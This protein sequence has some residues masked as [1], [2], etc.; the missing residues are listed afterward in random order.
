MKK[1]F[2]IIF[3]IYYLIFAIAAYAA[4]PTPTEKATPTPT[5]SEKTD[6][7][8]TL[9]ERI[10]SRVAELKL[11]ERRGIIGKV[12][13]V[14]NSQITLS[15]PNGNI[16]FVDVDELTKFASPSAKESFGISDIKKDDTLGI[17]G[18]YNKQSRRLLAR[19]IDV[20]VQQQFIHGA[21]TSLNEK[22]FIITVAT[23]DKKVLLVDVEKITKTLSYENKT[24]LT[25][26]GFSKIEEGQHII[27]IGFFDVKDK[28]R[29]IAS[30]VLLFPE[31]PKDPRIEISSQSLIPKAEV[32]PSTGSGKKLTPITR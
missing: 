24:G 26:S 15:D 13:D 20:V 25:K 21:V 10:A 16:R 7:F 32:T 17:L 9:K 4:S 27:V 28:T 14:T 3:T 22:E 5:K 8:D 23:D 6:I 30:R 19:F 11:V 31:I 12:T 1:I 29:V 2:F 18:L